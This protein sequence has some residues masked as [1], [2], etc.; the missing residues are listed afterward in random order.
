MT[1]W[2]RP[3]FRVFLTVFFRK[4]QISR[5]C[6]TNSRDTIDKPSVSNTH[7][8]RVPVQAWLTHN[9]DDVDLKAENMDCC[10]EIYYISMLS[11]F[12]KIHVQYTHKTD[13]LPSPKWSL[14]LSISGYSNQIDS[15]N[16][17]PDQHQ[18]TFSLLI[19]HL[20]FVQKGNQGIHLTLHSF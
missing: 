10:D 14:Y 2:G 13:C 4:I 18:M 15:E 6:H 19:L 11:R 8:F 5:N 1:L 3:C 12:R 7:F 20:Q 9:E 16:V 17:R